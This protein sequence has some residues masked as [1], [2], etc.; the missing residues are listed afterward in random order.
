MGG[1][2]ASPFM[3]MAG[4]RLTL[5]NTSG[6]CS[7]GFGAMPF[8]LGAD[9]RSVA[10]FRAIGSSPLGSKGD[11]T[12]LTDEFLFGRLLGAAGVG[13]CNALGVVSDGARFSNLGGRLLGAE[14]VGAP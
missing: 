1:S 8:T 10:P 14:D 7:V 6:D 13:I 9:R 2:R 12:L 4:M 3:M 5:L 11:S